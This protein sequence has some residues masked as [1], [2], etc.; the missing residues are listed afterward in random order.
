MLEYLRLLF[1]RGEPSATLEFLTLKNV[2]CRELISTVVPEVCQ[3]SA[4]DILAR[5]TAR[6]ASGYDQASQMASAAAYWQLSL[7]TLVVTSALITHGAWMA[8]FLLSVALL[9]M[10]AA[11]VAWQCS[12]IGISLFLH[13]TLTWWS[14]VY[15]FFESVRRWG[16]SGVGTISTH[17]SML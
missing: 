14:Y 6:L 7:G 13:W 16:R 3:G 1:T 11:Y 17:L 8:W 4:A 12:M 5:E 15:Y 10:Q 2:T 9:A